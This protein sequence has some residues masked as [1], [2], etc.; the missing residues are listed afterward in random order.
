MR[1]KP[2]IAKTRANTTA[3][4]ACGPVPTTIGKSGNIH[5][6]TPVPAVD[7]SKKTAAVIRSIMPMKTTRKPRM[8]SLI[9]VD[10]GGPP[11]TGASGLRRL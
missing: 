3:H 6:T 11:K 7:A 2:R 9:G 5:I 10:H 4:E 8:N 1:A